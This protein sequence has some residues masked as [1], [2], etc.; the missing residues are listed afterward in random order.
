MAV[1]RRIVVTWSGLTAL[2][3]VSVFYAPFGT[4]AGAD[5]M[6][7]LNAVKGVFPAALSWN[8]PTS[9]D[10]LTD[11]SGLL[12]G[13]WTA[14]TGGN[15]SGTGAGAYAAGTGAYVNWQT[16]TIIGSRRLKGRTFLC[17]LIVS[18]YTTTGIVGAGTLTTLQGAVTTL[19]ATGHLTVWHRPTGPGVNDGGSGTVTAGLVPAQVTS[20]RTRR[21]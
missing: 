15:V 4:D 5:L 6:T 20:L 11:T 9:G 18:T 19:A 17:P 21:F 16:A 12:T 13:A 3:G 1:L 8:V 2:P 14:G 7:F 10:T